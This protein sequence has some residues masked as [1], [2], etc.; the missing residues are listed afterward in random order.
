MKLDMIVSVPFY[1]WVIC[2]ALL[3]AIAFFAGW[4]LH[5]SHI[6]IKSAPKAEKKPKREKTPEGWTSWEI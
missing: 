6:L 2:A 4:S 5:K 3:V 1:V